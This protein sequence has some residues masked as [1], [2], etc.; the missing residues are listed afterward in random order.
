M[1][2]ASGE[3]AGIP[4]GWQTLGGPFNGSLSVTP[5]EGRFHVFVSDAE[6]GVFYRQWAPSHPDCPNA[7]W[8]LLKGFKG[9][10][11]SNL[12]EDGSVFVVGFQS[13]NPSCFKVLS[14]SHGWGNGGWISIPEPNTK[15][16]EL[17]RLT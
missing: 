9:P 14:S 8:L 6:R 3:N 16:P 15:A 13:G 11:S 5:Q 12:G 2:D 17:R 4:S 1:L 7:D 10:V